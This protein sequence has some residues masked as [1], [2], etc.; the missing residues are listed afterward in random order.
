[1]TL[2]EARTT[3]EACKWRT[4][5]LLD[6]REYLKKG[7]LSLYRHNSLADKPLWGRQI[8]DRAA[9]KAQPGQPTEPSQ[10]LPN[11]SGAE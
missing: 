5:G 3:S 4:N 7:L 6:R 10:Y 9:G 2:K 11:E 8:W 1:M